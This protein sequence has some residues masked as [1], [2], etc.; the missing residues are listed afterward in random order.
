MNVE[1]NAPPVE[2]DVAGAPADGA[3]ED[4]DDAPLLD[5]EDALAALGSGDELPLSCDVSSRAEANA[6]IADLD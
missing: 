4:E 5:P 1:A 6:R 2:R 3:G